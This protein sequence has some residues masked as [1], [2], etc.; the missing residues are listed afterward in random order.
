M[1]HPYYR[2]YFYP[3]PPQGYPGPGGMPAGYGPPEGYG[4]PWF[5]GMAPVVPPVGQEGNGAPVAG[6]VDL[7]GAGAAPRPLVNDWRPPEQE[8]TRWG[9]S[10]V[11]D[12]Q[13]GLARPQGQ[14]LARATLP[15]PGAVQVFVWWEPQTQPPPGST[16]EFQ[17]LVGIGTVTVP[18]TPWTVAG[19]GDGVARILLASSVQGGAM[20][21]VDRFPGKWVS[22]NY[23]FPQ[24]AVAD[25]RTLVGAIVAPVTGFF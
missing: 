8:L 16:P 19:A 25:G 13:N 6:P 21:F 9:V 7:A 3:M 14:E 5:E 15:L 17:V 24:P 11:V 1:T 22:V 20:P 23:R 18:A 2:R 10:T 4:P 12:L